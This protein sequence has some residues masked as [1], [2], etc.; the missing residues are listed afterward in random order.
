MRV[1]GKRKEIADH[2]VQVQSRQAKT[3]SIVIERKE[4][5]RYVISRSGNPG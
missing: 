4:V 2:V 1:N 5:G 3:I